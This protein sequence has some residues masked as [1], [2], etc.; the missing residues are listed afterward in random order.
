MSLRPPSQTIARHLV[1]A[2]GSRMS[3]ACTNGKMNPN[4]CADCLQSDHFMSETRGAETGRLQELMRCAVGLFQR[5][6]RVGGG[7]WDSPAPVPAVLDPEFGRERPS[8]P[9]GEKRAI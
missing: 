8:L 3:R 9:T 4:Y 6:H 2:L 5:G 7:T 1:R